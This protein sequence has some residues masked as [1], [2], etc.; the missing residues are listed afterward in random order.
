MK[1]S[2]IPIL[3]HKAAV[4]TPRLVV[5]NETFAP[6]VKKGARS[7]RK[8]PLAV[9]W[10]EAVAGRDADDV[11]AAFWHFL[12]QNRDMKRITIYADNCTA[13]QKSWLFV[14]MLITYLQQTSNIT[15]KITL[16]YLEPGHT[17]MSADSVH[18]VIQKKVAKSNTVCD[19]QD[20]VT[21]TECSGV[22]V[23]TMNPEDFLHFEDGVSRKKL[24]TLGKE[25]VRPNIHHF[26][27]LQARRG[28]E[29]IYV[30]TS[31][32]EQTWRT[33]DLMKATYD[34]TEAPPHRDAPRGVKQGKIEEI[35]RALLPLMPEHKR[36]FW[37]NLRDECA[38]SVRDLIK[39]SESNKL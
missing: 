5:F 25:R 33:Y 17:A 9:L 3:P 30:K 18:Q 38:R 27:V 4:F 8:K 6:V 29:K 12:L 31:H 11:A 2:L 34:S 35:C 19:F 20:F 24:T 10:H 7:D 28:S 37:K 32:T 26:R 16:K 15:E 23:K 13:Q 21:L 36:H 1:V 22:V 14:A 39:P